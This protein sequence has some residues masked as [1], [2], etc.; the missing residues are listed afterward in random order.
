VAGVVYGAIRASF[1][2]YSPHDKKTFVGWLR[3]T[4]AH[5]ITIHLERNV[6]QQKKKNTPQAAGAAAKISYGE[7]FVEILTVL[8][9]VTG[10]KGITKDE[11]LHSLPRLGL[12]TTVKNQSVAETLNK[13]PKI[14]AVGLKV[15]T[16]DV[17]ACDAVLELQNLCWGK[18]PSANKS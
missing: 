5:G 13:Q 18:I 7:L 16:H 11:H 3:G 17:E 2:R 4:V 12:M 6:M 15:T 8:E 10:F 9:K 14:K 1:K